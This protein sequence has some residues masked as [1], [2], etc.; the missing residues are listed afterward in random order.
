MISEFSSQV[1]FF[2]AEVNLMDHRPSIIAASAVLR[3]IDG[4]LTKEQF[5][6]KINDVISLWGSIENVSFLDR[7]EMG[8][9]KCEFS[10]SYLILLTGTCVF[11]LL[12]DGEHSDGKS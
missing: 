8:I 10:D 12:H 1:E 3:A 2:D 11:L 9:L 7:I 6:L 4:Q 5:E